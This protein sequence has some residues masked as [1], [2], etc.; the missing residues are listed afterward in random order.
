MGNKPRFDGSP[1]S[2]GPR[3][4]EDLEKSD[5]WT[6]IYYFLFIYLTEII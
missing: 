6:L 2:F 4:V 1:G 5:N 3:N